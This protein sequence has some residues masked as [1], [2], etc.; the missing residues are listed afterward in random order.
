MVEETAKCPKNAT[1]QNQRLA[2][3]AQ[4]KTPR[5]I[6]PFRAMARAHAHARA[7]RPH[8]WPAAAL[9]ADAC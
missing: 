9:R 1:A 5:F 2:I 3:L 8:A 4:L 6:A 7:T